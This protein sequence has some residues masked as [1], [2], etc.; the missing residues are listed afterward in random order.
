MMLHFGSSDKSAKI[1]SSVPSPQSDPVYGLSTIR[2][3]LPSAGAGRGRPA[4]IAVTTPWSYSAAAKLLP[5]RGLFTIF[6]GSELQR[7]FP[8][9]TYDWIGL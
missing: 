1:R 3:A 4:S 7:K 6:S 9:A 2:Q 5:P 8:A